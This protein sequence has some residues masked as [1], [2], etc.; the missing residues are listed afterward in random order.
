MASKAKGVNEKT[1]H[2]NV[3]TYYKD[4]RAK[5]MCEQWSNNMIY[6]RKTSPDLVHVPLSSDTLAIQ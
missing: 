2:Y 4:I 1:S 5:N 6:P 3:N